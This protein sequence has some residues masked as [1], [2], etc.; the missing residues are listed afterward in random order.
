MGEAAPH[1]ANMR[2]LT[3]EF[4]TVLL[5]SALA[6]FLIGTLQHYISFGIWG[7]G[8]GEVPFWLAC[9]EG[10]GLGG[11][12]GVPTGLLAYYVV[13]KRRVTN[14]QIAI[15]VLGSLVGGSLVGAAIFWPSAFVTPFLALLIA[16]V[17]G[18]AAAPT[19]KASTPS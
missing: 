1:S 3:M 19:A 5:G 13:L 8:F 18:F 7:D 10:G 14:Q 6:G 12:L 15:I 11:M 4:I 16:R 17:V 9:L 2:R